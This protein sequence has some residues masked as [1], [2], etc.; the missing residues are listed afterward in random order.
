SAGSILFIGSSSFTNW[1]DVQQYF[2]GKPILNRAFGGSTLADQV[3]YVED[4][5]FPYAPKQIVIYCGE[6]DLAADAAVTEDLV[7]YRFKQLFVRIREQFPATPV[8]FLSL[9]PS[10]SRAQLM[11]KMVRLNRMI[12]LFLKMKPNT[13]YV[14]VYSKMLTKDG[15]PRPEL[16]LK[17]KLHMNEKGYRIWQEALQDV[18]L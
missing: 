4:I 9:K 2:P 1:K 10:P 12:E 11:P 7:L 18:L 14:D 13:Q 6:N 8:V 16:F 15:K 17:D 5:V 3:R